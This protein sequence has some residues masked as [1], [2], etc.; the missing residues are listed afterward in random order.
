MDIEKI[1]VLPD[2]V[3]NQIAAGE[4]VGRPATV[5]KEM[6]DNDDDA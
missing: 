1:R 6:L 5:V 4:V 2:G 3:A